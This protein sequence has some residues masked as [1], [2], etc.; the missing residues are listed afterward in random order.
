MSVPG[1]GESSVPAPEFSTKHRSRSPS[2]EAEGDYI[3]IRE[4]ASDERGDEKHCPEADAAAFPLDSDTEYLSRL[5]WWEPLSIDSP[6]TTRTTNINLT[7]VFI[8]S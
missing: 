8:C 1:K 2:P 4:D 3:E 7:R 5:Y 6:L